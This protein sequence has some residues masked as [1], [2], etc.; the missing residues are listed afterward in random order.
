MNP[1]RM[2]VIGAG[3]MGE[4]HARVCRA[5][6]DVDLVGVTDIDKVRGRLV[7]DRYRV[8]FIDSFEEI[9]G[10]VD[11]VAVA[12]PTPLH[13]EQTRTCLLRGVHVFV[14]KAFTQFVEQ[15][16]ELDE[17][18]RTTG[19]LL[20]VGHIERFNPV[21]TEL[22]KLL[23][24]FRPV[25]FNFRRLSSFAASN[26][27]VD[28][29]LDL[30]IHDIDLAF[31]LCPGLPAADLR[32]VGRVVRSREIDHAV[33]H[34]G[35]LDGPMCSFTASRVT[36]HKVRCIEIT[37]H[38]AFIEADLLHKEIRVHRNVSSQYQIS[39]DS[40]KYQQRSVVEQLQV[41]A[42]EPLQVQMADFVQS[43]R[44]RRPPTVSAADG[45]RALR[46]VRDII[47][48]ISDMGH[49]RMPTTPPRP[50][51]AKRALRQPLW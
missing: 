30:M 13:F 40:V 25:A 39:G 4:R 24:Q 8:P 20:Q 23:T 26:L 36:E 41:P 11:A 31:D 2:G 48:Q 12:T 37:A 22:K 3:L 16:E 27:A 38:D 51:V 18:S 43:L 21:Y 6:P 45:V 34:L 33:A 9:L 32:A 19:L 10:M 29:V 46:A 28:V 7:A 50:P 5:L 44:E 35:F 49:G 15:G 1:T 17:L 47:D 14:E 42:V